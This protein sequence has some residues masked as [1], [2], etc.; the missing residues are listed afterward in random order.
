[1]IREI[2][3]VCRDDKDNKFLELAVNGNADYLITGDEDLLVLN[4]FQNIAIIKPNE[5]LLII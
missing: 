2:I 4:P 3:N 1:M 5:F